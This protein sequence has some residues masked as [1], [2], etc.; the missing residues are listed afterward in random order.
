MKS[1]TSVWDAD[2]ALGYGLHNTQNE[3]SKTPY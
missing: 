2:K 3:F 1:D